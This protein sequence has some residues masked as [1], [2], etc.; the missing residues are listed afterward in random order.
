[1]HIM[2]PVYAAGDSD[3][4]LTRTGT[5]RAGP[6]PRTASVLGPEAAAALRLAGLTPMAAQSESDV[7]EPPQSAAGPPGHTPSRVSDSLAV[8]VLTAR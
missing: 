6:G 8:A 3:P 5:D 7:G 2:K 4:D 1:M